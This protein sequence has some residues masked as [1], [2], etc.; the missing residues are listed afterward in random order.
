[1]IKG[2]FELIFTDINT[3]M[4]TVDQVFKIW[5]ESNQ[6]DEVYSQNCSLLNAVFS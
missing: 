2:S 6:L 3:L 4:A 1:M 5:R